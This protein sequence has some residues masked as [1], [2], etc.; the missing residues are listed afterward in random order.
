MPLV[1]FFGTTMRPWCGARPA[2]YS[3]TMHRYSAMVCRLRTQLLA[4]G[5]I[6]NGPASGKPS[7]ASAKGTRRGSRPSARYSSAVR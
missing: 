3:S 6:S 5:A 4:A 1:S 2:K 7:W